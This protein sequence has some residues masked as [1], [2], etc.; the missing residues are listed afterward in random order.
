M[1]SP[2]EVCD[3][4]LGQLYI[5]KFH[6]VYESSLHIFIIT[7]RGKL[8][9]ISTKLPTTTISLILIK[10]YQKVISQT[11]KFAPF[12]VRLKGERNVT[13]TTKIPPKGLST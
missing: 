10:H 1:I 8:Y 2:L 3:V 12:M 5:F 11:N 13:T 9:R 7:L 4:I 6:M